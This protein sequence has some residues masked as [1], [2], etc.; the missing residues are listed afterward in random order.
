VRPI[1]Y[2]NRLLFDLIQSLV[3]REESEY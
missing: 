2:N 3:N 1:V